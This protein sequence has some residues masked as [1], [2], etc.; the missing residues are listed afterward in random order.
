MFC[1][2]SP[3]HTRC[4][5][6]AA[7]GDAGRFFVVCEFFFVGE[8][9]IAVFVFVGIHRVTF[10]I[11]GHICFFAVEFARCVIVTAI[12]ARFVAGGVGV[13]VFG[14]GVGLTAKG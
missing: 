11:L 14:D 2:T 5:C 4:I 12:R 1:N 3:I 10:V 13:P 9:A 7:G 6:F 8:M